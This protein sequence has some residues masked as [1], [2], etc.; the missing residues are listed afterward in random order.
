MSDPTEAA[1]VWI[2]KDEEILDEVKEL[3]LSAGYSIT[4]EVMQ[5]L[6]VEDGR[7][8]VGPGKAEELHELEVP[9][10]IFAS[11]LTPAQTFNIQSRTEKT[12][13]DR[14]RLILE[15][16]RKRANSPESRLQVE[17]VDL[18]HQLPIVREFVHRGKLSERPGF[19]GGGEYGVDYYFNMIRKRMTRVR[20]DLE[21]H[22]ERREATRRLRRRR[23]AHLVAIAGYTNAGKSTLLNLVS[24]EEGTLKR[25]EVKDLL[26]TTLST[27]TR[28]MRGK[29]NCLVTDTVGFIRNL[30]PWMIEGFMSTLEEAFLADVVILVLDLSDSKDEMVRKLHSSLDILERGETAGSIL[31]VGNKVDTIPPKEIPDLRALVRAE[32]RGMVGG[33][34]HISALTGEGGAELIEMVQSLLPPLGG[35]RFRVPSGNLLEGVLEEVRRRYGIPVP[36]DDGWWS[37]ETEERWLGSIEKLVNRAGGSSEVVMGPYSGSGGL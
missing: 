7:F 6:R 25:A 21:A 18:H 19:M 12:V 24:E 17:L 30:P 1:L 29:R 14:I 9:I 10:L 8:Y 33:F 11:D 16:F 5:N 31:L 27:S 2:P 32:Q 3:A 26:F 13:I 36:G 23:G 37:V 15:I 22:R 20:E 28:R 4:V 34:H 35:I